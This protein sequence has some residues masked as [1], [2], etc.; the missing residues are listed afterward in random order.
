MKEDLSPFTR[1]DEVPAKAA[2]EEEDPL[3]RIALMKDYG[4][5]REFP[6]CSSGEDGIEI[7][8]RQT[9]Q[10]SGPELFRKAGNP[11]ASQKLATTLHGAP[12]SFMHLDPATGK[13]ATG[14]G[15]KASRQ[16]GQ[17]G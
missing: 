4:A 11:F 8:R 3:R 2:R 16:R 6:V 10:K 13:A 1:Q 7:L 14:P 5:L 15:I 17:K 12:W 9:R